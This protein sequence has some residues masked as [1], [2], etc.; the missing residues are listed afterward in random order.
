[1]KKQNYKLCPNCDY[2]CNVLEGKNYCPEC[3]VKLMD[4]CPN[5]D[6]EISFPYAK[7][8][9]FCGYPYRENKDSLKKIK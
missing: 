3:G 5:C 4:K 8:C 1:M 7:Y 2:F 6:R 9:E